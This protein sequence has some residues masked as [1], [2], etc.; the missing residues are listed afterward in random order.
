[1]K[2]FAGIETI[3]ELKQVYRQLA[4][5]NHPDLGGNVETMKEINTEYEVIFKLLNTDNKHDISDGFR[6]VIDKLI[7]FEGL[8]IEICGSWIWL[9]GNTYSHKRELKEAG[10]M[11]ANKKKMWYWRPEEAACSH[12]KGQDMNSIREKYGSQQI[13]NTYKP[14]FALN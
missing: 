9:S 12:S 11:W 8:D 10:C 1:M 4:K 6:V 7:N 5:K 14:A 13:K 2:H 3:E